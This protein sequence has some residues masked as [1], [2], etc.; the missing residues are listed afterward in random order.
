MVHHRRTFLL[1]SQQLYLAPAAYGVSWQEG[2]LK[3]VFFHANGWPTLSI[4]D[5]FSSSLAHQ[6]DSALWRR[7]FSRL[8]SSQPKSRLVKTPFPPGSSSSGFDLC[9]LFIFWGCSYK[10]NGVQ[11]RFSSFFTG[12]LLRLR[13]AHTITTAIQIRRTL[14]A[15]KPIPPSPLVASKSRRSEIKDCRSLGA[16]PQWKG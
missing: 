7:Q 12:V 14:R 2:P 5:S 16:L 4:C 10:K 3:F 15:I 9:T 11:L 13:G 1:C 8:N 6:L